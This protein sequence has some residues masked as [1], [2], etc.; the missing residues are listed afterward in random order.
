LSDKPK[1]PTVA[2]SKLKGRVFLQ[3][4]AYFFTGLIRPLSC[5][6]DEIII[7]LGSRFC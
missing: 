2:V 3:D 1:I 5:A 7:D 4:P 6:G